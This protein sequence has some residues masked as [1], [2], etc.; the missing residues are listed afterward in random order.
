MSSVSPSMFGLH[1]AVLEISQDLAWCAL[2]RR[3]AQTLAR[4]LQRLQTVVVGVHRHTD[5]LSLQTLAADAERLLG[6]QAQQHISLE[7]E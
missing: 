4:M 5:A 2:V 7:H 6:A 3:Q 1:D